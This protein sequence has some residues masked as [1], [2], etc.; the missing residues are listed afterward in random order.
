MDKITDSRQAKWK[1]SRWIVV[2]GTFAGLTAH[3][4][5]W[6]AGE[7]FSDALSSGGQG[8]EMVVIPAGSFRMGCV[9]SSRF[10]DLACDD[11]FDQLP[12]HEVRIPQPFGLSKYEVTVA[13][14]E[15]CVTAGGC[16]GYRP[17]DPGFH[18]GNI[19]ER[20]PVVNVSWDHAQA[21]VTW[22]SEETGE[23]YRLP[24]EAE[25]EYAVRAGTTTI[26]SWGNEVGEG[27]ANCSENS[28][29]DN[30]RNTA[31]VGSFPANAFGLHDMHGNVFEWVEDC[32]N[33]NYTGAPTDG[34]AWLSGDCSES[35]ARGGSW[36]S[37]R[38]GVRSAY[39]FGRNGVRGD[40]V[41]FRV[42]RTLDP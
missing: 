40:L 5:D 24:S 31:P 22:L 15:I 35:V 33:D 8:P 38:W 3:A 41:G 42:V 12:V 19:R 20:S 2:M 18:R 14:W 27:R 26:F 34:S 11:N 32:W 7:S 9:T 21:Y 16:N 37:P 25:W 29:G 28:C 36:N 39:R 4:Q 30:W 10:L 6:T 23:T 17:E 1:S 13:D